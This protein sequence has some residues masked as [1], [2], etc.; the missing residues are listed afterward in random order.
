[1]GEIAGKHW[2]Y[3]RKAWGKYKESMGKVGK[4]GGN[5]RKGNKWRK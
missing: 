4:H 3:S 1:M 2:G 5:S